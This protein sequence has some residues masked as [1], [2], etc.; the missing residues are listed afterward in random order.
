MILDI[1]AVVCFF[2]CLIINA[3]R[4]FVK[5]L[6]GF[7]GFF[8]AGVIT[9]TA[10]GAFSDAVHDTPAGETV[11]SRVFNTTYESIL[12]SSDE[13]VD[14]ALENVKLPDFIKERAKERSEEITENISYSLSESISEVVFELLA[15]GALFVILIL[16]FFVIKLIIPVILKLPV[17]KQADKSLGAVAGILNGV[18]ALYVLMLVVSIVMSISE[19]SWLKDAA[20]SSI[21]YEWFYEKSFLTKL[22]S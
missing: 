15:R 20:D 2:I 5:S 7:M 9:I 11:R 10:G 6:L 19:I 4:G 8:L 16:G 18:I 13:D 3:R 17:I 22:F 12:V 14:T 1:L 21:A